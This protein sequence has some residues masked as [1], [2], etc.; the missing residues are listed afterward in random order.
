MA[1]AAKSRWGLPSR[2]PPVGLRLPG[3]IYG[4]QSLIF[5]PS[6]S[7]DCRTVGHDP[8]P[9]QEQA[10]PHALTGRLT[11]PLVRVDACGGCGG[12]VLEE[13]LVM[14]KLFCAVMPASL[15]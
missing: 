3:S 2:K 6:S 8:A 5:E 10:V 12:F 14:T 1:Y 13:W 7:H 4:N 11:L 15:R 9:G